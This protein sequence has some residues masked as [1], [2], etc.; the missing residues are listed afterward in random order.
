MKTLMNAV[1]EERIS[2]GGALYT[3]KELIREMRVT[4]QSASAIDYFAFQSALSDAQI[5]RMNDLGCLLNT[6]AD[7]FPD[8][9][10][11]SRNERQ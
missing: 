7:V 9:Y 6:V 5:A 4:G 2:Y 3:R 10:N 11:Q 8:W 1:L